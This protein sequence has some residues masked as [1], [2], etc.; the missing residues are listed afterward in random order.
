[1][2]TLTLLQ[3]S[4]DRV[5][6]SS[7]PPAPRIDHPACLRSARTSSVRA[8][9]S[10]EPPPAPW[11]PI[12]EP[13]RCGIGVAACGTARALA[14]RTHLGCSR[15]VR[16]FLFTQGALEGCWRGELGLERAAGPD[17]SSI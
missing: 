16:Q 10:S 9:E 5:A 6:R 11:A 2:L 17:L 3:H 12:S 8:R 1:M 15:G 4:E 14:I 13:L 7:G